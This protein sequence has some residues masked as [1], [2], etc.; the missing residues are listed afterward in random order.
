MKLQN[1]GFLKKIDEKAK[2]NIIAGAAISTII[3]S[4]GV[5][6]PMLISSIV[7]LIQ[8]SLSVAMTVKNASQPNSKEQT[9]NN[10]ISSVAK[11]FENFTNNNNNNF[12]YQNYYHSTPYIRVSK[13]PQYTN[14]GFPI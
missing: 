4:V 1:F 5:L 13:N 3:W 7:Q 9:S 14:I 12:R 11:K 8:T 10:N 6:I 2:K